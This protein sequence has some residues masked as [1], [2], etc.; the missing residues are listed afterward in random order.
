MTVAMFVTVLTLALA[1]PAFLRVWSTLQLTETR[2]LLLDNLRFAQEE[3]QSSGTFGAVRMAKYAPRYGTFVG[4][5]Q[6][7]TTVFAPGINYVDGY[8][9]MQ[10]GNLTYDQLGNCQ[11][12]GVIRLTNG[13]QE[14][15]ITTYMGAGLI[16]PGG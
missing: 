2:Q 13:V 11:V 6:L 7:S 15:D 9:Q 3:G 10:N 1:V 16:S 5:K 14:L 4:G 8:L 12:S